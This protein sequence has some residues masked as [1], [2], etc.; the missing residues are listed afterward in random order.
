MESLLSSSQFFCS[1]MACISS[2]MSHP[3]LMFR[4]LGLA[5]NLVVSC[6]ICPSVGALGQSIY[7]R[8]L[9]Y[10][11]MTITRIMPRP[12]TRLEGWGWASHKELEVPELYTTIP[13]HMNRYSFIISHKLVENSFT[14]IEHMDR[15]GDPKF[16]SLSID[17]IRQSTLPP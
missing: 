13:D 2:C 11:T 7:L 3:E 5:N 15:K 14:Q 1:Y 16:A 6:D 12:G 9:C 8:A 10:M 17:I 4:E